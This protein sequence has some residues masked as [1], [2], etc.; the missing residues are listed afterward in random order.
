[1]NKRFLIAL[2]LAVFCLM[3]ISAVAL[4]TEAEDD[5]SDTHK[6]VV[7]E[8]ALA[9]WSAFEKSAGEV[10]EAALELSKAA[11]DEYSAYQVA[12]LKTD[13]AR[14]KKEDEKDEEK[15]KAIAEGIIILVELE[16]ASGLKLSKAA[17]VEFSV[18]RSELNKRKKLADNALKAAAITEWLVWDDAWE[19]FAF[20][21][22]N[23]TK[24]LQ[25]EM[26]I[27]I[28]RNSR[29]NISKDESERQTK[30][31]IKKHTDKLVELEKRKTKQ[32]NFYARLRQKDGWK[33]TSHRE[34]TTFELQGLLS[35]MKI[36]AHV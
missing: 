31:L 16:H 23:W 18:W 9:K 15:K 36:K 3:G 5:S 30:A 25:A 11:N 7:S 14:K 29:K 6:V 19:K 2:A 8:D 33:R 26:T 13:K 1:M 17:P 28:L 12:R 24:T 10:D 32:Q 20:Q 22:Q 27:L 4:S 35:L 21:M 34:R